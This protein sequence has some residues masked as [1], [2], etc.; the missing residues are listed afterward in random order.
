DPSRGYVLLHYRTLS[1]AEIEQHC[2]GE[3]P[4]ANRTLFNS[5]S[6]YH[7]STEHLTPFNWLNVRDHGVS[8]GDTTSG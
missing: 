1:N 7:G 5:T 6:T 8:S 3:K 2:P 4:A